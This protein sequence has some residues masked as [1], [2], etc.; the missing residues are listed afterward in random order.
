MSNNVALGER[1]KQVIKRAG[2]SQYAAA[3]RLGYSQPMIWKATKGEFSREFLERFAAAYEQDLDE[4]LALAG[5]ADP[6]ATISLAEQ[7]AARTA[8]VISG[9]QRFMDG[10][11]E[12]E[13]KFNRPVPVSFS[14]GKSTLTVLE[15]EQLLAHIEKKLAQEG[16]PEA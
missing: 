14:G 9:A 1:F 7:V 11:R 10:L 16:K 5:I 6:E 2:D 13:Q 12:L 15:A 3:D 4:W 8:S